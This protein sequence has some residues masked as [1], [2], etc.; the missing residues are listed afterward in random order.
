M[1]V[2]GLMGSNR[3]VGAKNI[4]RPETF[5]PSPFFDIGQNY[6]TKDN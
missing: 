5:Y 3:L 1:P 6:L 4:G 2:H